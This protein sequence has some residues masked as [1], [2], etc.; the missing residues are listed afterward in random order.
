MFNEPT[1]VES[2]VERI[3]ALGAENVKL[4][5]YLPYAD[6]GAYGQDKRRIASNERD[7]R[8]LEVKLEGMKHENV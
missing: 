1:T 6:H 8:Y 3:D 5:T 4:R 7:I 2:I